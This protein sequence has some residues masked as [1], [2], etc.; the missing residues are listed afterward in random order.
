M[1]FLNEPDGAGKWYKGNTHL[2]SVH[3]DGHLTVDNVAEQYA[4]EGFEF[5][6]VTDHWHCCQSQIQRLHLPVEIISGIEIDGFDHKGS[7][8]HFYSSQGP[9]FLSVQLTI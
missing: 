2:H 6:A 8:Y 4:R 3:S 5:I 1:T 7:Y 9:S